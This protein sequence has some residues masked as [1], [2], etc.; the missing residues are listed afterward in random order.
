MYIFLHLLSSVLVAT[1][2]EIIWNCDRIV[3]KIHHVILT[4][5]QIHFFVYLLNRKEPVCLI[6]NHKEIW[7]WPLVVEYS[8]HVIVRLT[9]FDQNYFCNLFKFYFKDLVIF[10]QVHEKLAC[11]MRKKSSFSKLPLYLFINFYLCSY[12]NVLVYHS[13]YAS[14]YQFS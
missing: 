11:L 2:M 6:E 1:L 3:N 10:L 8:C 5:K 12:I 9:Y 13:Y 14:R 4:N 7:R